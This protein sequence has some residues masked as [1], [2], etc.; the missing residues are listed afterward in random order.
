MEQEDRGL[1]EN[2]L[3]WGKPVGKVDTLVLGELISPK[4]QRIPWTNQEIT[5]KGSW[6]TSMVRLERREVKSE[7]IGE[8]VSFVQGVKPAKT[9]Q[10]DFA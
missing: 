8:G 10:S 5:T 1:G 7:G 3:R 4:R 6:V 2:T 9:G